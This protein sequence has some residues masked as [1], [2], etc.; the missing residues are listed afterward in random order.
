M[1]KITSRSKQAEKTKNKIYKNGVK[2]IIKRGYD[3][4][5]VEQI[6]KAAG[7]SV[8][9]YYY[10]FKSK[11]ELIREIYKKGDEYFLKE[12]AGKLKCSTLKDQIIEFFDAYASFNINNGI[13]MVK[14][15][16]NPD[17]KMFITDGRAMQQ[18]LVDIIEYWKN[19]GDLIKESSSIEICRILFIAARGVIYN[20]CLYDGSLNLNKEMNIVISKMIDGIIYETIN[21]KL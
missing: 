19:N 2:L 20:W 21:T 7:V 13:D 1:T 11:F 6:S 12:V 10:Y 9:T 5:T 8:G 15:L 17:N 16:Y 14:N 18:I 4:I 3:N